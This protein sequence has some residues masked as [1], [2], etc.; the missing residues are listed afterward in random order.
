MR[1]HKRADKLRVDEKEAATGSVPLCLVAGCDL[2]GTIQ[3]SYVDRR[4]RQCSTHWC[5]THVQ[6]V[7]GRSCCRRH[8]GVL[9]AIGNEPDAA[10]SLPDLENRA[11]SLVNWVGSHVDANLRSLLSRYSIADA[12]V[13][14]SWT[15]PVGSPSRRTWARHWKALSNA[16]ID[17]T[18][19]LEVSEAED[20]IVSACVDEE[21]VITVEPPWITARQHGLELTKEQDA[22]ARSYFYT[23]LVEALEAK[24]KARASN[25]GLPIPA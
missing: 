5:S 10:Q 15:R 24:L 19:S 25:T 3:C 11:P 4:Q 17:L 21:K 18:I 14:G 16:G 22:T 23:D 2:G 8:A 20:T 9:R 1:W 12:R 6:I 13:V 7:D